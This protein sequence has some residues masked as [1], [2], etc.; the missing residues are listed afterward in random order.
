MISDVL[1]RFDEA[2]DDPEPTLR[3]RSTVQTL[4]EEGWTRE[5]ALEALQEFRA[6]LQGAGREADEDVVLEVMDFVTGWSSPHVK[7]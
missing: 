7:L 4:L 1:P 3:L 6:Q 5:L 2:L